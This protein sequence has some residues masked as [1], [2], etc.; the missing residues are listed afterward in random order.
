[1]QEAH[2]VLL[3]KSN[4]VSSVS[5]EIAGPSSSS[6]VVYEIHGVLSDKENGGSLL[7]EKGAMGRE[8]SSSSL[9]EPVGLQETNGSSVLADRVQVPGL[10]LRLFEETEKY[11]Y[12]EKNLEN[13]D[14]S[15]ITCAPAGISHQEVS[16]VSDVESE[17]RSFDEKVEDYEKHVFEDKL[18]ATGGPV[19]YGSPRAEETNQHFGLAGDS[20]DVGINLCHDSNEGTFIEKKIETPCSSL[21]ISVNNEKL[22]MEA[23]E[24][25][26]E[27]AIEHCFPMDCLPTINGCQGRHLEETVSVKEIIVDAPE[28]VVLPLHEYIKMG[29]S[30]KG[31]FEQDGVLIKGS[32][33]VELEGVKGHLYLSYIAK[34]ILQLELVEQTQLN[35]DFRQHSF[36]ELHR[37]VD[38]VNK[39]QESNEILS[40]ELVQCKSELQSLAI[41][42]DEMETVR[43]TAREEIE[44]EHIKCTNLKIELHKSQDDLLNVSNE[45]AICRGS[46][47]ALQKENSK[48]LA[49]LLS[50][51]R[52]NEK[53][54]EEVELLSSEQIKLTA[55]LLAETDAKK[56]L[57]DERDS[58][59]TQNINILSELTAKEE[60]L[61]IALEK[62]N[63]L[64]DNLRDLW[65]CFEQLAE[66][67]FYLSCNFDVCIAKIKEMESWTFEPFCHA[68]KGKVSN[69]GLINCTSDISQPLYEEPN[70]NLSS[71]I[72]LKSNSLFHDYGFLIQKVDG[73]DSEGHALLKV[74]KE[75]LQEA[76]TILQDIEKSV[77]VMHTHSLSLS[78]SSGLA[79]RTGV[80][81]LIKAFESKTHHIGNVVDEEPSTLGERP[82]DSYALSKEK[83][84]SLSNTLNRMGLELGKVE[85][86]VMD[87]QQFREAL[88]KY[89]M[90]C[91]T[92]KHKN[93]SLQA[94]F[95]EFANK[96]VDYESKFYE[97]PN[98]IDELFQ[99]FN[100]E[101]AGFL[102]E[103]ESLKRDVGEEVFIL[104]Q[105]RDVLL[106]MIS[107]AFRRLDASTGLKV[108]EDL[109]TTSHVMVSVDAAIL[110]IEDLNG[111]LEE[112]NHN[113]STLH[114][115]HKEL[116]NSFVG[117]EK[118][119]ALVVELF[120]KFYSNLL[121]LIHEAQQN[122]GDAAI[123][124]DAEKVLE[125]LPEKCEVIIDYL[126]KLLSE[127]ACLMSRN[128][129]LDSDLSIRNQ[130]I[131]KLNAQLKEMELKSSIR[132]ELE[133]TLLNKTK[134]IEELKRRCF[135]L[136]NQ[137]EDH[138][139]VVSKDA[140][141]VVD[142]LNSPLLR[143]EELVS[144]Y[145]HNYE[146]I[147]E[148]VILSR[149]HLLDAHEQ[150]EVA[151][152][153][154]FLPLPIL[155]GHVLIPKVIT[156]HEKLKALTVSDVQK[157]TEIQI[158]KEGLSKVEETLEASCHELQLKASEVE[159]LEQKLSSVREKLSIA[160]AKGKG[161]I[162]Q[163]DGLKQSLLEKTSELE[164]SAQD[165]LLKEA[166][167]DELEA[168]L[169]SC[170]E[171]ERIEALESE[172][173]YI[174]NS[175]TVL[176]DSFLQKDS[177]LQRIEE[178]LEDLELPN[179]F[180]EKD[181]LEKIELLS[182]FAID[183]SSTVTDLDQKSLGERAHSDAEGY[184]VS[185]A[186]KN[187]RWPGSKEDFDELKQKHEE[188]QGK[189]YRLAEHN[190]MLEQSL[191]ERNNLV[192][193]W[194]EVLDRIA[195]P[196]HMKA[197][198]PEDK[199]EWLGRVLSE[200][201]QERDSLQLKIDNLELSSDMLIVDVEE[202][203]KKIS[204]LTAEVLAV[205]S[206]KEFLSESLENLRNE[207]FALSEKAF[208]DE[209]DRE[210]LQKELND[211]Q[212]K[213]I[214]NA[215]FEY[216]KDMENH[217][218]ILHSLVS[219]TLT[220]NDVA[221]FLSGGSL[222]EQLEDALRKLI[223]NY[224]GHLNKSSNIVPIN[225][226]FLDES[227]SDHGKMVPDESCPVHVNMVPEEILLAKESDLA[228]M[229]LEMDR[230]SNMLASV[231]QDRD[232]IFVKCQSLM[233]EVE[234]LK[235]QIEALNVDSN[236]DLEKYQSLVLELDAMG[237]QRNSLQEQLTQEEQKTVSVKEKLNLAVR[238]GKGLV[239]QRDSL[240]QTVDEMNALLE[241]LKIDHSQQTEALISE[242]SLLMHQLTDVEL[243]LQ[244]SNRNYNGLLTALHAID[245]Q[246]EANDIDPF[247]KLGVI[248]RIIF[249][250]RSSTAAAECEANKS[251]RAA[252]LLLTE[253]N[254]VQERNDVLQ[255]ELVKA[256]AS[257]AEYSKQ[258]DDFLSRLDHIMFS[259]FEE[260]NRLAM[261]LMDCMLVIDHL[262]KGLL[263]FSG[264]LSEVV[265][266][267][268]DLF[269][270]LDDLR[271]F[272]LDEFCSS[273]RNN[274]PHLS[275]SDI[276]ISSDQKSEEIFLSISDSA[277]FKMHQNLDE[278]LL[279]EH[280]ALANQ[281]L[282]ECMSHCT[283][284]RERICQH[285]VLLD[286]KRVYLLETVDA[287]KRKNSSLKDTS[288]S[289]K[290]DIRL[291]ES[292]LK[293][294]DTIISSIYRNLTLLYEVCSTSVMETFRRKSQITGNSQNFGEL[295]SYP[296]LEEVEGVHSINDNIKL[297]VE[298]IL[299]TMK[300]ARSTNEVFEGTEKELNA[301][302]L[303]L[304]RELQEKDL[305]MN[306]VCEE[307]VSQIKDS[308]AVA[309]R[310][311]ADLNSSRDQFSNLEKK[312]KTMEINRNSIEL[313]LNELQD[314]EALSKLLQ[315]RINS[316]TETLNAKDQEIEALMQA[317]D[318]QETQMEALESIKKES[319]N[320]LQQKVLQ[321]EN[322]EASHAK[323]MAKLSTTVNK[324]DELHNLS[325]SLLL[326]V[327]NLQSQLHERDLEIS[328]L[329]QEV[330]RCTNDFLAS[331]ENN[332]KYSS[333]LQ[334]L[335]TLVKGVI[336]QFG[337]PVQFD[338]QEA[339][340][341][342][343]YIDILGKKIASSIYELEELRAMVQCKDAL[344]ETEQGRIE[345]LL[346][347]VESLESSLHGKARLEQSQGGRDSEQ[348]RSSNSSGTL[349]FEQMMQ[350]NKASSA[351]IATIVR[352]GR[353]L[354]NDQIAIAIDS[355]KD[356]GVLEDEDDDKAHGFKSLTK[357]RLIPR[358]TR[359]IADRIDGIWV[360]AERL[361]MRQPTLRLAFFMYWVALHALLASFI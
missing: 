336:S 167:L 101:A 200:V 355:K 13:P 174:R 181:I 20:Q 96:V 327:E 301:T 176:R 255:D 195:L 47:D 264:I 138:E 340:Q 79:T 115:S 72:K 187:C 344:L 184:A 109:D 254:E 61:Q 59:S 334:E 225:E 93:N 100:R 164:K 293:K 353:K 121:E 274:Q 119:H 56:E 324:F 345:E 114:D 5:H 166:L 335:L 24:R 361:L 241:Q 247:E 46:V 69:E 49:S 283:E 36:H 196:S 236:A 168:K 190:Q 218:Q 29:S 221:D 9:H 220:E 10:N 205:K 32:Y 192:Q 148:Q 302:I 191:L 55:A 159:Q 30:L 94:S 268:V 273:D 88:K 240:K 37:L 180:H 286:K 54:V 280:F 297:M 105:E 288:E 217:L 52:A 210:N 60:K 78:G 328:F 126:R 3:E 279:F 6:P 15:Q 316:L 158:L 189:Y 360:S 124:S 284:L 65:S 354:N 171:V 251:K 278:T 233:L 2:G 212:D 135:L 91:E 90:D 352:S 70:V 275:S 325:E 41:M 314:V 14:S 183:H 248:N 83:T 356:D 26:N 308:E 359:P 250:M 125:F 27:R 263:G 231:E 261:N 207:H 179:D 77:Q 322:L 23:G 202:S 245:L 111:K 204:E 244:H 341:M 343:M 309:K 139:V 257:I 216:Y 162:V 141:I 33:A 358:A 188:L 258:K 50:E 227:S 123:T 142:S 108:L 349:E 209:Q 211:L 74:L 235:R 150:M 104:K 147:R 237:K 201:K 243:N 326:E 269:H 151:A 265:S 267:E 152:D 43:L 97:M 42:K 213:L 347:R 127:R 197:M 130:E 16:V 146:E 80:S 222:I 154:C 287:V 98:H 298:C 320:L 102:D 92:Q 39:A 303:T 67:K 329:R 17:K 333:E 66:E 272:T 134:E 116:K 103:I 223:D 312:V 199:I 1:M 224:T 306:R 163:R 137:L 208:N 122:I 173:S 300:D 348:Q 170:L 305:Q 186:N 193:K 11:T 295:P 232:A 73:K 323:A 271:E 81:N 35:E 276:P 140:S 8:T 185:D 175:A 292:K 311:V 282:H 285:S 339:N 338:Y 165:L 21:E 172:L 95:D 143:L 38:L 239:Q 118:R 289:L 214:D 71:T 31:Q 106:G 155:I 238:K 319:E 68:Q 144:S 332:K 25:T 342:H 256:E 86:H 7:M 246:S 346:S 82:D 76:K 99:H 58:L 112:S 252:E 149:N 48:L 4:G 228:S 64:Q 145:L 351:S 357:S 22:Q 242:K 89:K 51:T 206:E 113:Y 321:L 177:V 129:E 34:D 219:S 62:K 45:L 253:L 28:E 75:H 307:L 19:L 296:N 120:Y 259:H 84:L 299:S 12:P 260:R 182:R 262:R 226:T 198:E 317:L 132:D 291:L 156:L 229:S 160:V 157:E 44:Q 194:E 249:D 110:R 87:S 117:F 136:V 85:M 310:S 203:H 313:R 128:T 133:N 63:E 40:A 330:T 270:F 290:T 169:K 57:A 131:E 18:K 315:E 266:K 304:Q 215:Q 294:K 153:E 53:L 230:I 277:Q 318:E 331:Q 350:R 337:G 161:L 178:V 234:D 107:E 281:A